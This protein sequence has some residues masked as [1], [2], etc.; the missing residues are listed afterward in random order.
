MLPVFTTQAEGE[1]YFRD[2]SNYHKYINDDSRMGPAML[3][4]LKASGWDVPASA[5][6]IALMP[7]ITPSANGH[8][9]RT[10]VAA[11]VAEEPAPT[12]PAEMI[13]L[14]AVP[15][16]ECVVQREANEAQVPVPDFVAIAKAAVARGEKRIV[17]IM[18]GGKN[19]LIPWAANEKNTAD[20]VDTRIDSDTTEQWETHYREHLNKI[21]DKFTNVNACVI[22][23]PT[24][25]LFTDIDTYAEWKAAY[26]A[27]SGEPYPVTYTTSA[28]ENRAQ[29]HWLQTDATRDLGNVPQ[30]QID[31]I[32]FSVRQHNYYVLA[33]FSVHPK[34]FV[35]RAVVDAPA[36]AMPDK[37][38]EF[39]RALKGK[40]RATNL[41][42]NAKAGK[43]GDDAPRTERGLI[44]HGAINP[45]LVQQATALRAL[46]VGGEA[47]ETTLLQLAED[48]CEKPIDKAAVIQVAESFGKYESTTLLLNQQPDAPAT[49]EAAP[50]VGLLID[51]S[52]KWEFAISPEEY[53][54]EIE[55][56]FPVI[57]LKEGPGPTWDDSVMYGIAG[58][59]VRKASVYNEAHPAGMYLDL[60]VSFGNLVGRDPYFNV[61]ATQHY[62]NEFM[63]RVGE[64]ST[65]RKGTGRD[66]INELLHLIDPK[67]YTERVKGGFGSA[68]AIV[69][70]LRD[71][72][73]QNIRK[74]DSFKEIFV[75]G[76]KDKRLMIREGEL[77]SIFQLAGKAESRADVVLRDGWDSKPLQNLVKGKTGGLSN[78]NSCQYPHLSISADTTRSELLAKLPPG[79][80]SN[81]FGN[82][83]LYCYV[84]RVKKCPSG[85]PQVNW[86]A[87]IQKLHE[88]LMFARDL[89]YVGMQKSANAVWN[90]M[91]LQ[92]EQENEAISG[93]AASMTARAAA[94]VRRLALILCLMDNHDIVETHHLHAAKRIWDYCQ[95]SARYIFGGLT[96][97]QEMI[98]GWVRR[99]GP[100]TVPQITQKLFHKHRKTDWV[101]SQVNGLILA[102]RVAVNGEQITAK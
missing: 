18:I 46:K 78:S 97:D 4:A 75:P 56:E 62:A 32:D 15:S 88:A 51:P 68:E 53:E 71:D 6:S 91:Y 58:D 73:V 8:G 57:P 70:E 44:P 84:R 50:I 12:A 20:G 48:N 26:E 96:K 102:G 38:V 74:K 9:T 14:D 90:R 41:E 22:A 87:E 76:I 67:W 94:H 24:E 31:G 99:N 83:F 65:S 16:T 80:E 28:R 64:S 33:E 43:V 63:V 19:P 95:D 89:R 49:P 54:I 5:A 100:V 10:E 29:E 40:A 60:I 27:F 81:G 35:Y 52:D 45:W 23:K 25:R 92:I 82:R 3:T 101:R 47:L 66:A 21:A 55:K 61:N 59:I 98:L 86:V 39:I 11:A 2:P 7:S 85:G 30:F 34:G 37:M 1:A 79:A 36:I 17:P 42:A 13:A 69:N 77:A 72:S 93:L